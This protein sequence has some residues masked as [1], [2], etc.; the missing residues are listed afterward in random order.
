MTITFTALPTDTVHALRKGGPDAYG[1]PAERAVATGLGEPCRHCLRNIPG[2]AAMLIAAY[3]PFDGL[4][5]YAETGP[6]FLCA[7]HCP[8]HAGGADLPEILT[9]APDY[10]V[11]GYAADERIVYG[12]GRIVTPEAMAA[13]SGEILARREIAYVHVRSA[14]NNCYLTRIERA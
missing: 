5:P 7:D 10:L 3:R 12:T 11:K 14:R 2:G 1:Q 13:Y 6:V 9:T 4:H 8:R